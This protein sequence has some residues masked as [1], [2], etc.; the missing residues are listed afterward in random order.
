MR[1]AAAPVRTLP[2]PHPCA[3]AT[4]GTRRP[5]RPVTAT[6]T[7]VLPA[8]L[9]ALARVRNRLAGELC[10][11]MWSADRTWAVLLA[12]QEALANAVEH[13]SVPGATIEVVLAVGRRRGFVSVRDGGR[14]GGSLPMGAPR[15]PPA[16]ETSG[17]GR[18]LMAMLADRCEVRPSGTGTTVD[19]LFLSACGRGIRA[20][21]RPDRTA[22]GDS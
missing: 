11:R 18:M 8:E 15:M 9:D 20:A 14:P 5:R 2:R 13:G 4:A 12:V 3:A 19:L 21:A 22:A 10:R 1:P 6:A 7:L 17:R 16:G